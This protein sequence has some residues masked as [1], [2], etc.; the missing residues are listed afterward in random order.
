MIHMFSGDAVVLC[1]FL[2]CCVALAHLIQIYW[3][4]RHVPGPPL[5]ALTDLW[6]FFKFW[7]G[8]GFENLCKELHSRY[9]PVVRLGPRRILFAQPEAIPIIYSATHV[10]RKVLYTPPL[11][12]KFER[13]N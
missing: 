7:T 10:Y 3:P 1:G 6:Y 4:L 11:I 13:V 5:A 9:G 12:A 8:T 2:L